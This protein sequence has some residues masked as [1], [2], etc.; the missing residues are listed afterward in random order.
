MWYKAM[1]ELDESEFQK[2][3]DK[4]QQKA[5]P[6]AGGLIKKPNGATILMVPQDPADL[7]GLCD[8]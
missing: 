5:E 3:V 2:D 4:W 7:T 8:I 6:G 1:I